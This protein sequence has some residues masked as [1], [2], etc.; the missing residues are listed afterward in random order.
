MKLTKLKGNHHALKARIQLPLPLTRWN[1]PRQKA[2]TTPQKKEFSCLCRWPDETRKD[3]RQ[4]SCH[5][6]RNS[7][8]SAFGS[9]KLARLK[10]NHRALK[11]RI[12]LPLPLTRWNSPSSKATIMPLK[13]EFSCLCRWPDETHQAQ[14][15]L[16]SSETRIQLL[17]PQSH[18]NHSWLKTQNCAKL[19]FCIP[20]VKRDGSRF[21]SE[22]KILTGYIAISDISINLVQCLVNIVWIIHHT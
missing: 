10:G 16:L 3:Q 5:K 17:L 11:A 15:Q 13:Q 1:S 22:Q 4:P 18:K 7:V 6:S 14:R 21:V 8:A 9:M 20:H 19:G 2:T 12:Q